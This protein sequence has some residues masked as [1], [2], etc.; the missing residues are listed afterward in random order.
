[1][2]ISSYQD[3]EA[4]FAHM[5][6]RLA[7][8]SRAQDA[9]FSS[10]YTVNVW[11]NHAIEPILSLARPYQ[12][13]GRYSVEYRISG[14]AD[15]L[16]FHGH[17]PADIELFWIDSSRFLLQMVLDEWLDWLDERL[18]TLRAISAAPIIVAT[19][20]QSNS[21]EPSRLSE[22]LDAM[23]NVFYANLREVCDE[24]G[25]T[26]LDTRTATISGTP[27]SNRS[28]TLIARKLACHWL[29]A[30]V[31]PPIK[32]LALDLDNTLHAGILGED[33][34]HGVQLTD[35]HKLLQQTVKSIQQRGIFVA[36][37]SRNELADVELLFAIRNDYPL[38]WGDFS[39]TE[40]SWG[41]KTDALERIATALRISLDAVL[42]VDD[43]PGELA[44]VLARLPCIHTAFATP[45]ALQTKRVI[46]YYPGLWR[47][48][49]EADD[50]KRVQDLKAN[51]ERELL[52]RETIDQSDYFRELQTKL[53]FRYDPLD[54]LGRLAGLCNKT[55]QFNLSMRRLNQAQLAEYMAR[56]D[57]A[58]AS[59]QMSD[60]LSDS[61]VIAVIVAERRGNLLMVEEVCISCRA[62]G[63]GLEDALILEAIRG[64]AIV[65]GCDCIMFHAQ[66]GPRNQPA[67]NWLTE[68]LN[69]GKEVEEG[70]HSIPVK[71]LV[72]FV[73]PDGI[74][75]NKE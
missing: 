53:D 19:W 13:Y 67:F 49:I 15:T 5:P 24:A 66:L 17:Q 31:F 42:F 34:I 29:P 32:A 40:I 6:S 33:G 55:N 46:E 47:W 26:F 61:G 41:D 35:G 45:D 48:K 27:I 8:Q 11:R 3:Q 50:T 59:V 71:W 74:L 70:V 39:A 75:Q 43:N 63:R 30:T 23:P 4:L 52:L 14:Y 25:I 12:S 44:S 36:L 68:L 10:R 57:A 51:A 16:T 38:R 54:Q 65:D 18:R 20:I 73:P 2:D 62:L 28:Q 69:N 1:M 22:M 56:P 72:D 9:C 58:V 64:M 60:R 7:L 37:V 21:D